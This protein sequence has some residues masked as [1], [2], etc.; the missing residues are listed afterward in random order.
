[1]RW[2]LPK[3]FGSL[4]ELTLCCDPRRNFSTFR[5]FSAR[6]Y[7]SY[8]CLTSR[9]PRSKLGQL[10]P[11]LQRLLQ[12]RPCTDVFKL[13]SR[14]DCFIFL[15]YCLCSGQSLDIA[16]IYFWAAFLTSRWTDFADFYCHCGSTQ[17]GRI[18]TNDLFRVF[19]RSHKVCN[20]VLRILRHH[21]RSF[22]C[23]NNWNYNTM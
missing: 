15:F 11:I 19:A 1:M 20:D 16:W 4:S 10:S 6:A 22:T 12:T 23:C 21:Y 13:S 17:S 14:R 2:G 18:S 8:T 5:G 7:Q 3:H 9:L